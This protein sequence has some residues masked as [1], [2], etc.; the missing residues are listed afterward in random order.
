M[1]MG[2]SS[3]VV[4]MDI[5]LYNIKTYQ[6]QFSAAMAS[7]VRDAGKFFEDKLRSHTSLRCHS[8]KDLARLGHPYSRSRGG[9]GVGHWWAEVHAPSGAMLSSLYGEDHVGGGEAIGGGVSAFSGYIEVGFKPEKAPEVN[10]VIEGTTK[11]IPRPIVALAFDRYYDATK[12]KIISAMGN[13]HTG[14]VGRFRKVRGT[15]STGGF[16]MGGLGIAGGLA[17]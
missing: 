3:V 11:M 16:G 13:A 9:G 5:T 6:D 7:G 14:A 17:G 1:G 15:V 4:G 10:W 2:D 8:Q 12:R